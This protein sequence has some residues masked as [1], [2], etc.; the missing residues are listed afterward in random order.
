M[1]F[2]TNLRYLR[3]KTG[4]TQGEL[5]VEL[6]IGRTTVA[7]YEAGVSEPSMEILMNIISH[8]GI[9]ADMLLSRNLTK[10][11]YVPGSPMTP[12]VK[13]G[14]GY[15]Q[16]PKVITV[17][18]RGNDNILFVPVKARAGYLNGLGDPEF[19]E[20]LPTFR[21]PGLDHSTYR[22]FEVEGPSMTPNLQPGDKVIGEWVEDL[23][24]L[25]D[26]HVYIIVHDGGVVVKRIINRIKE[27]GKILLKSDTI[28]HRSEYP[29]V[30]IDPSDIKEAWY[31]KLK[32]STDFTEP[33]E[34]YH[35][36]ADL[37]TDVMEMK[38][39]LRES[40]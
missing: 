30:E 17:D 18:S 25:R 6:G 34:V 16:M 36:I 24:L 32:L 5:S 20:S 26:N 13:P 40:R 22:M 1:N 12:S 38:K 35:R 29:V 39:F 19:M 2:P 37:E 3:K 33:A 23:M 8:F 27:S 7:N 4:K 15:S 11:G 21:L 28:A 14:V 31:G 9:S 10:E